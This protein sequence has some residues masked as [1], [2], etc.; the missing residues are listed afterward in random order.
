MT[1]KL[2]GPLI[3]KPSE[4]WGDINTTVISNSH[5]RSTIGFPVKALGSE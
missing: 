1:I 2:E 4:S 3:S 5:D